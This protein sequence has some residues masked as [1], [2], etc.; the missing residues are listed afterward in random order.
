[1]VASLT[2]GVVYRP[3]CTPVRFRSCDARTQP[4]SGARARTSASCWPRTSRSRP[5]SR[6]AP[7]PSARSSRRPGC[8]GRSRRRWRAP[9]A[10]TWTRVAS[11]S[12][13]IG[14]A[15][16]FAP[17]PD[18]LRAE[19]DQRYGEL[20]RLVGDE[21]PPVAV[22]SS[23]LGEDSAEASHAGQQESFL[24]VRGARARLRRGPRLLGE[25]LHAAGDQLSRGDR[26]R[27]VGA[28]DGRHRPAHGRCRGLGRAVHVQPGHR[29][30]EHGR[31]QR[32]LGPRD[33]G[34]R[35]ARSLRTTTS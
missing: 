32:E 29:R 22:R 11:A 4:S 17:F 23:A 21:Q 18:A 7:T 20:A 16:R 28:G 5:A 8:R 31:G 12:K 9:R 13:A 2:S 33:R 6:S 27:G 1:M 25:P 3:P 19:L 34:R 26:G 14:E 35:A 30:P 24:W 10:E 15:M